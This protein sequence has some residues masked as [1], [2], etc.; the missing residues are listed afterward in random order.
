MDEQKKKSDF[1]SE[2]GK[3]H[4]PSVL[5]VKGRTGGSIWTLVLSRGSGSRH[6]GFG[7][8]P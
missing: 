7:F 5:V 2:G 4:I 3:H 8:Q 1:F 6:P